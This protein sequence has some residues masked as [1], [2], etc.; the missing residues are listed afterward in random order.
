V[1]DHFGSRFSKQERETLGE[2]LG[3]LPLADATCLSGDAS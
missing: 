3:R 2:L 1:V